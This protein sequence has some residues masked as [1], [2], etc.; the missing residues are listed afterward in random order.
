MKGAEIFDL[1]GRVAIATGASIGLR[2]QM[3][4]ALA[5]NGRK[6]GVV[7]AQERALRAS[8]GVVRKMRSEDSRSRLRR[9]RFEQH[10][11][12]CGRRGFRIRPSRYPY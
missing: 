10:P 9:Q 4:D 3:A 5:E 1:C 2:R 8:R 7:R 6:C 12:S 11:S